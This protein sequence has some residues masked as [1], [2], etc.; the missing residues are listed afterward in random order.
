MKINIKNEIYSDFLALK[1]LGSQDI[2]AT[3]TSN[4]L[5]EF[6]NHHRSMESN[7]KAKY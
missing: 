1:S 2:S 3:N 4:H 7:S 5:T 6:K